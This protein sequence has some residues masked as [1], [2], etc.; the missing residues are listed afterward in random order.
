M[1]WTTISF[2]SSGTAPLLPVALTHNMSSIIL[3][4][5]S[6]FDCRQLGLLLV[7]IFTIPRKEWEWG[8]RE[9]LNDATA[10]YYFSK[11]ENI[12]QRISGTW[13]EPNLKLFISK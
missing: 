5:C 13:F 4:V 10:N 12:C 9:K 2:H 6:K 8:K 11:K 3:T 7:K 1:Y